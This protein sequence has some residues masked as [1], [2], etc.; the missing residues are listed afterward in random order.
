MLESSSGV[1]DLYLDSV[2]FDPPLPEP[3]IG[4]Q[5]RIDVAGDP[6]TAWDTLYT[7]RLSIDGVLA[8]SWDAEGAPCGLVCYTDPYPVGIH[9]WTIEIDADGDVAETDEGNNTA[10]GQFEIEG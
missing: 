6:P 9:E 10:Y 4:F 5:F 3:G 8:C 7:V 2:S 1:P